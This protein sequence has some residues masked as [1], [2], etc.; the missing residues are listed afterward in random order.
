MMNIEET[1]KKVDLL[2]QDR[3]LTSEY[4]EQAVRQ[5][6]Y[7]LFVAIEIYKFMTVAER[8]KSGWWYRNFFKHIFPL[9]GFLKERKRKRDKEKSPLHPSYKKESGVL[10]KDEKNSLSPLSRQVSVL[11]ER[12][13]QFWAE[14]E[15]YIGK[16]GKEMVENF[17]Y[18]WAEKM[19]GL[20]KMRWEQEEGWTTGYRLAAW[21]RRSFN[22]NDQVASIRLTKAKAGKKKE[23]KVNE[24]QVAIAR[25]RMIA[26]EKREQE[27]DE[28]KK[29]SVS[30]EE[31]LQQHPDSNLR[32][33]KK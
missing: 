33:F 10:E 31:W 13:K 4:Q 17:Y 14:L 6:L 25:Q 5:L 23:A 12:R 22:S 15:P 20:D 28:A 29:N 18:Y 32:M 26:D 3:G 30:M 1:T 11:D 16:Y 7:H 19:N 2:L 24:Q 8:N 27:T 21:K 9:T